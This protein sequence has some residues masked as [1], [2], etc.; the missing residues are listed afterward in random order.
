MREV[1][2]ARA[3]RNFYRTW[4]TSLEQQ[5][6]ELSVTNRQLRDANNALQQLQDVQNSETLG[7]L[8]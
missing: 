7:V 3:A 1:R 2:K 6:H 8:R 4:I 5:L